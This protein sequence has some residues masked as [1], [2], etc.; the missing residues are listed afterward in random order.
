MSEAA[1]QALEQALACHRAPAR[2]AAAQSRPLPEGML[3]LL[4]LA[5]GDQAMAA[6]CAQASGVS[7]AMVAEAAAFFIQQVLFAPGA[8]SYRMLGVNPDAPDERIKEHYR[9]LVR[10]L[11]PD[12]NTDGWDSVYADR[13]NIAWQSLRTPERRRSYDE[14]LASGRVPVASLDATPR[15]RPLPGQAGRHAAPEPPMLSPDTVEKLPVIVLGGLG[16][17]AIALL[18]MMWLSADR[19]EVRAPRVA[20]ATAPEEPVAALQ[21][22]ADSE[23]AAIKAEP[24]PGV[25]EA[26]AAQVALQPLPEAEAPPPITVAVAVPPPPIAVTDEPRVAA[27]VQAD[28]PKPIVAPVPRAAPAVAAAAPALVE[29]PAPVAAAAPA[30]DTLQEAQAHELLRRF[31][32]AYEAGDISALMRLFTPDAR[33]N[34]GGLAAIAYDY[35]SLFS[36]SDARELR[37]SPT[38]WLARDDGG[39]V[40][41]RYEAVVL[42][43]G[44]PR[45]DITR[46]DIRFDLRLENGVARISVVKHD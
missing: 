32:Q 21:A 42:V 28:R 22:W 2:L 30:P 41:A 1:G 27:P 37:L 10:W 25:P 11:H 23:Q 9:W 46:G 13:V 45:P 12:R 4:R 24:A 6:E 18:L 35:Q 43:D 16:G 3:V 40:L 39:T 20:A 26:Y 8:N 36:T 38:G 14:D 5:A 29:A 7:E 19:P 34:R 33:N 31:S 15:G 17:V 44:R